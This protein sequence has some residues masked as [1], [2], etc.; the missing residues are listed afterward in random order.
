M[1]TSAPIAPKNFGEMKREDPNC[2]HGADT[3]SA[4]AQQ[5]VEA[6]A[7]TGC[8]EFSTEKRDPETRAMESTAVSAPLWPRELRNGPLQTR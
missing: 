1:R 6:D 3:G 2:K 4:P 5:E 7:Q 8:Y